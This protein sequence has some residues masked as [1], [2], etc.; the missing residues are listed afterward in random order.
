MNISHLTTKIKHPSLSRPFARTISNK[1]PK[2]SKLISAKESNIAK[3]DIPKNHH[4]TDRNKHF[5]SLK[6]EEKSHETLPYDYKS[7]FVSR[8]NLIYGTNMKFYQGIDERESCRYM[9]NLYVENFP[10]IV[11]LPNWSAWDAQKLNNPK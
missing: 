6:N 1:H 3:R 11:I 8:D 7:P 4:L 10:R 5:V 9:N 2:Q